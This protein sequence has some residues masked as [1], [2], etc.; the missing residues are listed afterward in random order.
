MRLMR[1]GQRF[2]Y[3]F[4]APQHGEV[5][6]SME[7]VSATWTEEGLYPFRPPQKLGRC[8]RP[9]FGS[10]PGNSVVDFCTGTHAVFMAG[11]REWL[12]GFGVAGALKCFSDIGHSLSAA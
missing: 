6:S 11:P 7:G 12:F 8:K 1:R 9:I 4:T 10:F 5:N 3:S 2:E